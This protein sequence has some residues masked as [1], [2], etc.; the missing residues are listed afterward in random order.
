MRSWESPT[1]RS[2][3]I[4]ADKTHQHFFVYKFIEITGCCFLLTFFQSF[5]RTTYVFFDAGQAK[6]P[7][8]VAR[9]IDILVYS[10][11]RFRRSVYHFSIQIFQGVLFLV[12]LVFF[13]YLNSISNPSHV[14]SKPSISAH[15]MTSLFPKF[16]CTGQ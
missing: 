12:D 14:L 3:F 7:N 11:I 2:R 10:H 5:L 4:V 15:V 16:G 1:M 8:N 9:Q 13:Y 6:I